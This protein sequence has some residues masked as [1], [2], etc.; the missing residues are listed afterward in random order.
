MDLQVRVWG[1]RGSG[2]ETGAEYQEY[3]GNT[4]CMT[5]HTKDRTVI[6]DAGTG[7]GNFARYYKQQTDRKSADTLLASPHYAA[8]QTHLDL[9]ISHFHVDHLMG[10]YAASFL[11]DPQMEVHIYGERWGKSS[12]Q[13]NLCR[14]FG[15]PYW[16]V[17]LDQLPAKVVFHEIQAGNSFS[18]GKRI[19]VRTMR[20]SHPG[21]SI[22]YRLDVTEDGSEDSCLEEKCRTGG[23]SPNVHQ[24]RVVY[25]LDCELTDAMMPQLAEFARDSDLLICDACYTE[26]ELARRQGWGH[27]SIERC[28]KLRQLSGTQKAL[29][30]HY[31]RSYT[32]TFLRQQEEQ[33]MTQDPA[34]LFAREGMVL[35]L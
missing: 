10:L 13:E 9:L 26:A 12:L 34:C 31:E 7:L 35:E 32:D 20:G 15:P 18:L 1:V 33:S 17:R 25:G 8:R 21:G 11:F 28:R 22:L 23:H 3:G 5:V 24:A 2:P 6:L 29:L 30:T 27:G 16:P 4:S 19:Q 14:I